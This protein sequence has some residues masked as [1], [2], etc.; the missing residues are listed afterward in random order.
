MTLSSVQ[1]HPTAI[2]EQ[3]A[4]I[5]V[6]VEIGAYVIIGKHV[7]IGKN[8]RIHAHAL[9]NGHTFIGEENEVYS[10][11][12]VGN[13]PQDL[14]Y[15]G[16]PTVLEIGTRNIIREFTTL[17]PGTVQGG[18][19]TTIGNENLFMAYTHVA[20]DCTVG[21]QN[22]L[23]NGVQLAG[24]VTIHNM[25]VLGGLSAVH[26]FVHIGDMA[27]L[28]GGSLTVKDIP[29]Y[30]MSEG[31]RAILRGLNME[32]MRRRNIS[33]EVRN[34][35]KN[36]YKIFFYQGHPT[37]EAALEA[38]GSLMSFPEVEKFAHFIRDSKRGVAHPH[39]FHSKLSSLE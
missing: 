7:K 34:A 10:Y 16:E 19:K 13:P 15:K 18:G 27:M 38:I 28:A 4:E 12:A 33:T 14:K 5:D 25:T 2:I 8:T 30:C 37:T 21:N 17:Q 35:I 20:H 36:A 22:I 31:G 26:Q 6:G 24:H 9:I 1:I 3:G 23:A 29:P 32:G 39:T 11:A